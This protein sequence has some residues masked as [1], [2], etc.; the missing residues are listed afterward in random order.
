MLLFNTDTAETEDEGKS[1]LPDMTLSM[2][3]QTIMQ[4]TYFQ[5]WWN[6]YELGLILLF[7]NWVASKQ[8]FQE[9]T[10][11]CKTHIANAIQIS[12]SRTTEDIAVPFVHLDH[13]AW[14]ATWAHDLAGVLFIGVA[15]HSLKILSKVPFG[16][17]TKVTAIT[18]IFVHSEILPFYL[19]LGILLFSFAFGFFFAYGDEVGDFRHPSPSWWNVF[20]MTLMGADLPG[21]DQMEGSNIGKL[22]SNLM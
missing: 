2:F 20:S 13:A 17:G 16:V 11:V 1:Q 7:W 18:S 4:S 15:M 21:T 3:G 5:S 14:Y 12:S 22:F 8:K 9:I 6:L 19:V 10:N